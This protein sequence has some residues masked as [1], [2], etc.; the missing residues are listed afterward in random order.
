MAGNRFNERYV[1]SRS[2]EGRAR[3]WLALLGPGAS[4]RRAG[5]FRYDPTRSALLVIDMQRYFLSP[6]SHAYLPAAPAI[7]ENVRRLAVSYRKLHLPIVF[8]RHALLPDEDAGLMGRWWGDVLREG[9]PR[10]RIIDA[11]KPGPGDT[12]LRKSKYSAFLGTP[13]DDSLRE[14][15]VEQL[16][17]TGVLTHL[18][19]ETTAREAFSLG[20][21]V[22][23][24][25]DATATQREE[26]HVASL[27]TLS[28]GFAV[29]VAVEDVRSCLER[30]LR[31]SR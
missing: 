3:E 28:S 5:R 8:T 9:D 15:G 12:V 20:Y 19:C 14:S 26:L 13:L 29:P 22:Y 31:T 11:L 21:E 18:C 1:T 7:V 30:T 27:R 6:S 23:F 10:S 25:V 4:S 17:I 16:L 2:L 24:P